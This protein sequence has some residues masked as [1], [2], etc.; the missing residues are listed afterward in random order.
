[1]NQSSFNFIYHLNKYTAPIIWAIR[2][3][4]IQLLSSS[5]VA[6]YQRKRAT[7]L[8]LWKNLF[9]ICGIWI[10]MG[11]GLRAQTP[12]NDYLKIA[13]EQNPSLKAKYNQ[14]LVALENINQQDV[15]PDPNLSFGYFIS[16]VETRVGAQQLRLSISQMFP[17]MG[18]LKTREQAASM[19]A[20]A[21]FEE[22]EEAKNLLF[23]NVKTKWLA[24]LE[25]Q[26]EIRITTE[27]L[28]ILRSYE[29]ITKTKYE[30]SLV[31]LA[32]LV[33]VQIT[34]EQS[35][36]RLELLELKKSSLL[37]DFNTLLNR[38]LN[39]EVLINESI[40]ISEQHTAS[41]DSALVHQSGIKAAQANLEA[42]ESEIV[43]S[44][45]KR[46]PN[47]GVGLDYVMVNKRTDMSLPDNGKDVLMPMV[48]VSLPVFGKKNQSIIKEAE[49]KKEV[50]T[51]QYYGLQNQVRNVWNTTEFDIQTSLKEIEQIDSEMNKTQTLLSVL[52]SEY[53]NDNRNFEDLLATQQ[54]LLQLQLAK[55][56]SKIKHREALYKRE[57][58]TGSTLN[59]FK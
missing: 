38:E 8:Y 5:Q 47:I 30:A 27:N 53:T 16:P 36:T 18:T 56:K 9:Y 22:F 35:E 52:T 17:W 45:L 6:V 51:G 44:E 59:Q 3:I 34:V 4:S 54:K 46:K 32:D 7:K 29:P 12:L 19:M 57:Y 43:L 50:I 37:G 13:A 15:L 41:L 58:L 49:L 2:S 23:L 24:L 1:M 25:I 14:Y 21:K 40:E 42:V 10:M 28:R 55:I 11:M 33:R 26:E 31:S 48:T 20:K 39:R